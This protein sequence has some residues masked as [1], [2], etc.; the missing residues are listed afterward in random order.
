MPETERSMLDRLRVKY[1]ATFKNGGYVGRR[2]T[3]AEQVPTDAGRWGGHRSADFIALDHW[4][5]PFLE[6]TETEKAEWRELQV[7][8]SRK[9]IHGHEVKV[10]RSDL[11]TE[12]NDLSK[13]EAW[14]Q[15]C[16]Y[17]WLVVPSPDL[18]EGFALP[19]AWGV[20]V[21]HGKSLRLLKP[22]SRRHAA[23]MPAEV[24]SGLTRAVAKTEAD[25]AADKILSVLQEE[26]VRK[27][28]RLAL[29]MPQFLAKKLPVR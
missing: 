28:R 25:V 19:E 3:M 17:W 6:L 23:L 7:S 8:A 13:S 22:A 29:S 26:D 27:A 14:A 1:G 21:A 10:S 20:Y 4:N 9:S 2:Y 24:L 11:R 18:I 12:L 15:H 16:N 5:I